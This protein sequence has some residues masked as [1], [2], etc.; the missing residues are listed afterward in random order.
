MSGLSLGA[1]SLA[2]ANWFSSIKDAITGH[3][4]DVIERATVSDEFAPGNVQLSNNFRE[5][6]PGVDAAHWVKGTAQVIRDHSTGKRYVQLQDNFKAGLAPDLYI[7][8]SSAEKHIVDEASFYS[9]G[10][11]ELGKLSKGSGASYYEIPNGIKVNSITIW[12][13]RFEQFMGSTSL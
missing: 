7:Y 2:S 5:D 6:D 9:V 12:C 4:T 3:T 11:V 1:P 8:I 13:R 10:Q